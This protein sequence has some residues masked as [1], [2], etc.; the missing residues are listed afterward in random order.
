[1]YSLSAEHWH[2][3]DQA[4]GCLKYGAEPVD[5]S[6]KPGP[7]ADD[8]PVMCV[9]A[10]L[11]SCVL[12]PACPLP[13]DQVTESARLTC[14]TP[15]GARLMKRLYIIKHSSSTSNASGSQPLR[16]SSSLAVTSSNQQHNGVQA[17]H[18]LTLMC[19]PPTSTMLDMTETCT[20]HML[21][22]KAALG[23]K[24]QHTAS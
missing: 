13:A 8:T 7:F 5:T 11:P 18:M 21:S 15:K 12:L 1:M 3:L 9:V 22:I 19:W 20:Q 4:E 14:A 17:A 24:A 6:S 23:V 2:T 10:G 16:G